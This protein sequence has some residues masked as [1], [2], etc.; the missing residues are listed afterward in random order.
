MDDSDI[1]QLDSLG[2]PP[3]ADGDATRQVAQVAQHTA[4]FDG[5]LLARGVALV[6]AVR[7]D[8][9][10]D[11]FEGGF[12]EAGEEGGRDAGWPGLEAGG[13]RVVSWVVVGAEWRRA[14]GPIAVGPSAG[15]AVP[16]S[17][18]R[19]GR[20]LAV[21]TAAEAAEARHPAVA[22]VAVAVVLLL[23]LPPEELHCAPGCRGDPQERRG[24]GERK[25]SGS[26]ARVE[27]ESSAGGQGC[28]RRGSTGLMIKAPPPLWLLTNVRHARPR[29]LVW[30]GSVVLGGCRCFSRGVEATQPLQSQPGK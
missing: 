11:V 25:A 8:K 26:R 5:A 4:I 6:H 2:P 22:A 17:A 28:K 14:E 23:V 18:V 7:A 12:R 20:L 30:F 29:C 13:L 3:P 10:E 21:G 9:G 16:V 19:R 1:Q 15:L 24:N 27:W